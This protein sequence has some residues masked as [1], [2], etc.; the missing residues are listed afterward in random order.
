MPNFSPWYQLWWLPLMAL[1]Q[2]PVL[3]R[4]VEL[5]AWT[6]PLYY[7]VRVSTHAFGLVHETWGLCVAGLWP[8][9]LALLEWRALTGIKS[10]AT[11]AD[12]PAGS[13]GKPLH[14]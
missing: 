2:A 6:G 9:G 10:P 14:E 13:A 3:D 4:I 11:A 5:L 8:A 7:L 1:A 12:A